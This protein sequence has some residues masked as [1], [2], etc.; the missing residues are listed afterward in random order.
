VS[1]RQI[2]FLG[3]FTNPAVESAFRQRNFRD[4]RWLITFLIPAAMA[5]VALYVLADYQHFGVTSA[6]W[7]LLVC[8]VLFLLFSAWVL[9]AIRRASSAVA[10][11]R[12]FF[13]WAALLGVITICALSA[14]PPSNTALLLISFVVALVAYCVTPLTLPRQLFLALGY[15]TA[16]LLLSCRT[17]GATLGTVAVTYGMANLFGAITSWRVNHRR[18]EAYLGALREAELRASLQEALAEIRTLRGLLCICAWC[19]RIR[20]EAE[21]WQTVESYVQDRTHAAFT[22][23]ICPDCLRAQ[24]EESAGASRF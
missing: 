7:P 2:G 17:D 23:G 20:D 13:G 16:V 15:S 9:F 3:V 11:D 22:H 24:V 19:K 12:L 5:R 4:D 18:R 6:F 8:R 10:A 1:E 21:S 14:R